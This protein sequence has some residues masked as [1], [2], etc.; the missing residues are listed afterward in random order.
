MTPDELRKVRLNLDDWGGYE[1]DE[2]E[3]FHIKIWCAE[4]DAAADA[5]QAV[6]NA[7]E[8]DQTWNRGLEAALTSAM[9]RLEAAETPTR[10][11]LE[12]AK[13]ALNRRVD[14]GGPWLHADWILERMENILA[15]LAGEEK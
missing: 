9:E 13:L 8:L 15:A 1:A 3:K 10:R 2:V 6:I 5:W 4:L 7:H 12:M 14:E 11:T